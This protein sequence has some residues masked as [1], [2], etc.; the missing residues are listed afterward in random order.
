VT[1]IIV[2]YMW[3][4]WPFSPYEAQSAR[5][6]L[7]ASV[8]QAAGGH[9]HYWPV[10]SCPAPPALLLRVQVQEMDLLHVSRLGPTCLRVVTSLIAPFQASL[11][12][13]RIAPSP[14]LCEAPLLSRRSHIVPRLFVERSSLNTPW[15]SLA[16]KPRT[17][18]VNRSPAAAFRAAGPGSPRLALCRPRCLT[19]HPR[20]GC[21]SSWT[22]LR[23][24]STSPAGPHGSKW[25]PCNEHSVSNG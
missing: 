11:H 15:A 17:G 18:L 16:T 12:S 23:P 22:S 21:S 7:N 10:R 24:P 20:G 2:T 9:T 6:K 14:F 19:G 8:L 1:Y 4:G 25:R 3:N 5:L 13:H